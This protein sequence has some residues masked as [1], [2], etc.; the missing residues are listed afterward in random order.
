MSQAP[1]FG[2]CFEDTE[3]GRTWRGPGR[4]ITETDVT[5]F[6]MFT[7]DWYPLHVDKEYAAGSWAGERIA[8]GALTLSIMSGALPLAPGDLEAF[9]AI[10]SCRFVACVRIGDTIRSDFEVVDCSRRDGSDN[11]RVGVAVTVRNQ[12]DEVVMEAN[13]LVAQ[14]ARSTR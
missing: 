1:L 9:L 7:G 12:R 6:A 3:V 10:E 5:L 11:G 2:S 8:H 13:L 14:R 4:T